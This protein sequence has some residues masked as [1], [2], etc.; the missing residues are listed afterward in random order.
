VKVTSVRGD[1][2]PSLPR[3]AKPKNLKDR[4]VSVGDGESVTDLVSQLF[5]RFLMGQM[6]IDRP[7][8]TVTS[9]VSPTRN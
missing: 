9:H 7:H 5:E 3:L 2:A 8:S 4:I 6:E 1:Q